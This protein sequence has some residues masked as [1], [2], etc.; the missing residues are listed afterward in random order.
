MPLWWFTSVV[1]ESNWIRWYKLQNIS[2]GKCQ[3]ICFVLF[4]CGYIIIFEW[5]HVSLVR[6]IPGLLTRLVPD[7]T[8]PRYVWFL[9]YNAVSLE[10][11]LQCEIEI[12]LA[13]F[14]N[15]WN[16]SVFISWKTNIA[17]HRAY[18]HDYGQIHSTYFSRRNISSLAQ[19]KRH[20]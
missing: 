17:I 15:S 7:K 6:C 14:V 19:E 20:H 18:R 5:I 2:Q 12:K 11:C 13:F 16:E 9:R 10:S 8:K 4:S 3:W 1:L